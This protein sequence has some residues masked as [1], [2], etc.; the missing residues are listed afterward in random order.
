[1]VVSA[2][3]PAVAE[4]LAGLGFRDAPLEKHVQMNEK[5][6]ANWTDAIENEE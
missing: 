6:I 2:R 5:D 3:T 1:M 4:A